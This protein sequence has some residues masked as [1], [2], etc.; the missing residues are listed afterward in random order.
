MGQSLDRP[1][2]KWLRK[3]IKHGLMSYEEA[4]LMWLL[5]L[6]DNRAKVPMPE[7]LHPACERMWLY[8]VPAQGVA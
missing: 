8:E 3:A 6:V 1:L 4:R 7:C 5:D 2:P